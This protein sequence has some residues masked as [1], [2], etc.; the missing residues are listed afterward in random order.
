[1]ECGNKHKYRVKRRSRTSCPYV[2]LPA[3]GAKLLIFVDVFVDVVLR[4]GHDFFNIVSTWEATSFSPAR[5]SSRKTK[6][7]DATNEM[8]S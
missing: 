1:M 4:P 5:L 6:C 2:H 7:N 3:I 8:E